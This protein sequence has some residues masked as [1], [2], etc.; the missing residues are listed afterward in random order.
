M[1]ATAKEVILKVDEEC[2][3][4]KHPEQIYFWPKFMNLVQTIQCH[5]GEYASVLGVC[6]ATTRQFIFN[7]L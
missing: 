1:S 3:N 2:V 5:M 6:M 4:D 7:I